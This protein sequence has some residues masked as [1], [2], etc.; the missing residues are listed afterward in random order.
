MQGTSSDVLVIS[1][2]SFES[3]DIASWLLGT[4]FKGRLVLLLEPEDEAPSFVPCELVAQLTKPVKM[5]D[6]NPVFKPHRNAMTE[7]IL[8]SEKI[9]ELLARRDSINLDC[10]PEFRSQNEKLSG[11]E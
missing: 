3:Y 9:D 10:Q 1:V 4:G 7:R 2:A 11:F 6:F 5:S 8:D